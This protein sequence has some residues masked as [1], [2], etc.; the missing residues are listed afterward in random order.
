[1]AHQAAPAREIDSQNHSRTT[2]RGTLPFAQRVFNV[3]AEQFEKV[4]SRYYRL[5]DREWCMLAA[6]VASRRTR[7]GVA[8]PHNC[9]SA[10]GTRVGAGRPPHEL[11][12]LTMG[13]GTKCVAE[14]KRCRDGNILMDS[15]AEVIARRA[16]KRCV[17]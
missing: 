12:V 8:T 3:V 7:D 9:Q 5:Q 11:T 4:Q 14:S 15:H 13:T 16:L 1:M 2:L 6:I 17:A 10:V